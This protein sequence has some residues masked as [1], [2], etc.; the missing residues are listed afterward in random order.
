MLDKDDLDENAQLAAIHQKLLNGPGRKAY[1]KMVAEADPAIAIPEVEMDKELQAV[2]K[3]LHDKI[4]ELEKA[5]TQNA[6]MLNMEK[7]RAPLKAKGLNDEE[8]G[9]VEKFMTEKQ[10]FNHEIAYDVYQR[11]SKIAEP[12]TSFTAVE[13]PKTEGLL[14]D[15]INWARQEAFK[16]VNEINAAR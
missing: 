5:N 12:T 3:P 4:A 10:I 8:I 16:A 1:L 15:P 11:N 7:R 2:T 9:K 14:K 13:M 6:A